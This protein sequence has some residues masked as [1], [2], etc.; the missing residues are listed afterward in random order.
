[1]RQ[2]TRLFGGVGVM[3][4]ALGCSAAERDWLG[5]I[6]DGQGNP[7]H[8]HAG[9]GQGGSGTGGSGTGGSA[10][11]GGFEPCSGSS[12]ILD[13]V[14]AEVSADLARLD[15]GD[16][17]TA[18]YFSLANEAG[19]L[20]CGA[21]LDTSRQAVLELV[22]Q[23]SLDAVLT[24]PTPVNADATLY[25]IN[26]RDYQ[27]DRPV[28]VNGTQF[29]D[30]WEALVASSVYA[31]ELVGDDADDAK[32]SSGTN[33][34]VIPG[35]AFVAAATSAPVYYGVL[36]IPEDLDAFILNDLGI[37]VA[38]NQSD[39]ELVRAG[40]DGTGLGNDEFLLERFDIEVRAGYV[41]QIFSDPAGDAAL[42][43]DPLGTPDSQERE[44][45]FT[46]PNGLL[47]HA[48]A[49]ADGQRIDSSDLLVD[50]LE[51]DFRAKVALS[52]LRFRNQGM[53]GSDGL[54]ALAASEPERFSPEEL[55]AIF[56]IYRAEGDLATVLEDDRLGPSQAL[57]ALGGSIDAPDPSAQVAAQ[58]DADLDLQTAAGDLFVTPDFLEENLLLLAPEL[59]VLNGGSIDRGDFDVFYLE[60]LCILSVVNENTPNPA[61]CD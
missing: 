40:L 42:V 29:V 11:G 46:L 14:Y 53:T 2:C 37:D 20:G 35:N 47:A 10:G 6:L 15:A 50:T 38:Q 19:V 8:G 26:L 34:P 56:E 44:L 18:R 27:W 17:G 61:L 45:L 3:W 9:S 31:V 59:A 7:G 48:L 25:R 55:D 13:D 12:F 1:M 16:Q 43:E 4:L 24:P 58:F 32:S 36:G 23:L 41:W 30:V 28:E 54:R 33:V 22:N 51:T 21:A 57:E 60:S 5:D 52:Y 49:D 39:R